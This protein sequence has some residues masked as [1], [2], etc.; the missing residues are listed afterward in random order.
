MEKDSFSLSWVVEG[1]HLGGDLIYGTLELHFKDL[2]RVN[3]IPESFDR[4][5][6]WSVFGHLCLLVPLN[7]LKYGFRVI[8][9]LIYC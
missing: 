2:V 4:G 8:Y 1:R 7:E 6:P 5:Q 3:L 9:F